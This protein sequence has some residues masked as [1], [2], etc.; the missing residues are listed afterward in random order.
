[1]IERAEFI[2]LGE[3]ILHFIDVYGVLRY[4][5]FEK[6]FP[7]SK[8]VIDYLLKKQR[9][10]K[11]PDGSYIGADRDFRVDRHMLA[12]L[13]VLAALCEKVRSH[14]R[15][16]APAQISFITHSGDFYEIIYIG[17]GMEAMT[18]ASIGSEIAA[19]QQTREY[20]ENVKRIIIV[21]NKNQMEGLQISGIT[22]L[23]LVHPDGSL[24]Y[25]RS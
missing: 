20:T 5:D 1:V 24:S 10:Y 16:A 12:A 25:Y 2:K 7:N 23:A 19:K 3:E 17:Y 14:T 6:F 9:L 8:K 11:S 21:E 18:A 15:A 22:Q 13:S 4:A